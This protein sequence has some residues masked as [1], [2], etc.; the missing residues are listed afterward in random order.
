MLRFL[1]IVIIMTILL[2]SITYL[3]YRGEWWGLPTYWIEIL[4]FVLFMTVVVYYK[5]NKLRVR[6]PEAFTQFYLLS[7]VLKMIG[8]LT[9]I[10]F[11]VWDNPASTIG[12]VTLF[13]VSYL[14]LTFLEVYFL[15]GRPTR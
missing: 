15:L 2:G 8:G 10:S 14:T 6:Q 5:L 3:G 9:L 7:I 12:N 4:F 13:M 1:T 11:I